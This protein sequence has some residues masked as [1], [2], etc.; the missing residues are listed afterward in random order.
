MEGVTNTA[1]TVNK[2]AND[3]GTAALKFE[4]L[5]PALALRSSKI[6]PL[7]GLRLRAIQSVL[8]PRLAQTLEAPWVGW[9]TR[10]TSF[11]EVPLHR[12]S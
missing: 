2:M 12:G 9:A 3:A 11:T 6:S 1:R 4:A 5:L 8:W 10:P 7:P